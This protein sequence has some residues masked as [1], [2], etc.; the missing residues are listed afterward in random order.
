QLSAHPA[1]SNKKSE[2]AKPQS[3]RTA[4]G[5]RAQLKRGSVGNFIRE[6]N[7]YPAR[8]RSRFCNNL[9]Q[10]REKLSRHRSSVRTTDSNSTTP[11]AE[12]PNRASRVDV[13]R[14]V[15]RRNHN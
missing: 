5:I 8:Y 3:Y 14:T 9:S 2:P 13:H 11:T 15:A 12:S 4:S 10:R 6:L 1:L 7:L